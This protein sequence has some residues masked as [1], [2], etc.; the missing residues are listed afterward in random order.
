MYRTQT[1]MRAPV[2][3]LPA[4]VRLCPSVF[5]HSSQTQSYELHQT[6]PPP[7]GPHGGPADQKILIAACHANPIHIPGA[8]SV[9]NG[10]AVK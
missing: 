3:T 5:V 7:G 1:D 8:G 9:M 2:G 10:E 6:P 4:C